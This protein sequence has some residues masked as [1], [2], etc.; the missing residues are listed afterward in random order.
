MIP[1]SLPYTCTWSIWVFRCGSL[2][3]SLCITKWHSGR[4][5]AHLAVSTEWVL[6]QINKIVCV[7]WIDLSLWPLRWG[8]YDYTK[9]TNCYLVTTCSF[10]PPLWC[11]EYRYRNTVA[12]EHEWTVQINNNTHSQ[13]PWCFLVHSCKTSLDK[14][15]PAHKLWD[16]PHNL[17]IFKTIV[18]TV[19][20]QRV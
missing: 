10:Q 4:S 19:V 11:Q 3:K 17:Y 15:Q 20:H 18:W 12:M 6:F 2:W 7:N 13:L 14:F 16:F 1:A 9:S 5:R 8:Q